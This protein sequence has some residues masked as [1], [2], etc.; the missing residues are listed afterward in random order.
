[1]SSKTGADLKVGDIGKVIVIY[2]R[3]DP[4]CL[5]A[6]RGLLTDISTD[7]DADYIRDR[8]GGPLRAHRHTCINL[9]L[10]GATVTIYPDTEIEVVE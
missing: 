4:D 6:H 10:E 2:G 9:Q 7:T 8:L 3:R 5:V 1:M